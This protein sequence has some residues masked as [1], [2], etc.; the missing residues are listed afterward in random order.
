M[1]A[2]AVFP[3]QPNSIHFTQLD[4]PRIDQIPNGR[5]VLVKVLHRHLQ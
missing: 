3:R 2:V 4:Q 1:K 5:G